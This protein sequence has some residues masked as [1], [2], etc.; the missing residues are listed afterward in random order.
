[1]K[2]FVYGSLKRGFGNHGLLE[3]S[4]FI[5]TT[6][7]KSKS[8]GMVSLTA[9]PAVYEGGNCSIEGELYEVDSTTLF[10]LDM[11]EGNGEFYERQVVEL[12]SGDSAWMYCI[13]PGTISTDSS[14]HNKVRVRTENNVETWLMP[15]DND[16]DVFGTE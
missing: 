11:L 15:L 3:W 5:A 8:F 12:E 9:F 4:D 16:E 2:V 14:K 6:R 7:T 1:M 13:V 10:F